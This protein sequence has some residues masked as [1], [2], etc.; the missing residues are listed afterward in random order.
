MKIHIQKESNAISSKSL[1]AGASIVDISPEEGIELAGYPHYPRHNTGIHD[2]LYASCLFLDDGQ[3]ELA[4][5]AMDLAMYSK[6]YVRSLR[7][8][9]SQQTDIPGPNIMVCAS[10]THSGPWASGR[11]DFE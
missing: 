8:R 6:A 1:R 4:I 7:N 2:P 10:H 9:I 5:V 3:I 11:L